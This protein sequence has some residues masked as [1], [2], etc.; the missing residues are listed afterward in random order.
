LERLLLVVVPLG[1][2]SLVAYIVGTPSMPN[3]L[4][5]GGTVGTALAWVAFLTFKPGWPYAIRAGSLV[6]TFLITVFLAYMRVGFLGNGALIGGLAVVL[7]GLF[8]GRRAMLAVLALAVAAPVIGALG[9][10]TGVLA[11]PEPSLVSLANLRPWMRTTIIAAATWSILG[12]AVTYAV[13]HIEAALAKEREALRVLR[14]E[15]QKRAFLAAISH[16]LRTPL[17]G[18]LGMVD[19]LS[20]TSLDREQRR[21]VEVAGSSGK[22]LMSVIND[23]LD[24]SKIEAGRLDLEETPFQLDPIVREAARMLELAAEEKRLALSCETSPGL[25]RVVVGDPGRLRQVLVNLIGNAVKFTDRGTVVVRAVVD[26]ESEQDATIRFEVRDTGIGIEPAARAKLFLPF[27]QVDASTTRKF[28][29]SGLG[30]AICDGLVRRMG[31]QIGVTSEPGAGSTFWFT[32]PF[33]KSNEVALPQP[34]AGAHILL[35]EDSDVNAAVAAGILRMAGYTFDRV[36]DGIRAVEAV[37]SGSYDLVLMDCHLPG[38]DGYEATRK[39][40]ALDSK[41]RPILA[42]TASVAKEDLDRASASGMDDF[43][44]KPIDAEQLLSKIAKHLP[45]RRPDER[46]SG[47]APPPRRKI[48]DVERALQRLQGNRALFEQVTKQLV[49]G[50]SGENSRLR[51]AVEKRDPSAIRYAVHRLRGQAAAFD[52]VPL[53]T[54]ID[55]L[56]EA[57]AGARWAAADALCVT[58]QTE[59]DGLVAE[60]TSR[61]RS[62]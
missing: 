1:T 13:E 50:A 3:R 45:A 17:N 20:H 58:V 54:A 52:A 8:F 47:A 22:L 18:I 30:L 48:A 21:C 36:G 60:L 10:L 38:L 23:I 61:A 51:Q 33:G 11:L 29:G 53:M 24:F 46:A 37:R 32:V 35:V 16:E 15:Q 14:D 7:T 4:L 26:G 39:I 40:R 2:L 6:G 57:A 25:P 44:S 12:L 19:M 9:M 31:G 59:L 34:V 27:S 43:V 42:M 49:D 56:T 62:V 28:G 41:R 55:D 5:L